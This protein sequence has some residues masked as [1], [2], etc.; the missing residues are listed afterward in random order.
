MT[1]YID[2]S[3]TQVAGRQSH[4]SRLQPFARGGADNVIRMLFGSRLP[5]GSSS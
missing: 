1:W 5:V 2:A 3:K 4:R